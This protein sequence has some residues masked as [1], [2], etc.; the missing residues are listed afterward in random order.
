MWR[1]KK[2]CERRENE[3]RQTSFSF[4]QLTTTTAE[5]AAVERKRKV[6]KEIF[7]GCPNTNAEKK[8]RENCS[9]ILEFFLLSLRMLF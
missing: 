7:N 1:K 5:A 4:K 9:R 2:K 8:K 6:K 3:Q